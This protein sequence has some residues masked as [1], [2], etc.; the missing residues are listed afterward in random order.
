MS[1]PT[2]GNVE[3]GLG[4]QLPYLAFSY[5]GSSETYVPGAVPG[6]DGNEKCSDGL[7]CLMDNY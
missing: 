6:G 2:V 4:V 3:A 1:V 7:M 5:W